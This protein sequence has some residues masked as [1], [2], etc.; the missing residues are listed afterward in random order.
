MLASMA[1]FWFYTTRICFLLKTTV[2]KRVFTMMVVAAAAA[3]VMTACNRNRVAD[4]SK[5]NPADTVGLAD[6]QQW[7]DANAKEPVV[8]HTNTKTVVVTQPASSQTAPVVQKKGW[9]KSAKYAVIGGVT[10]GVLGA[11][12]NKKNRAAGA[13]IG[14][15]IGGGGGYVIG[16]D[17]DKKDG[18]IH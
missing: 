1:S 8:T 12:V 6:Y 18:R 11:V 3:V 14:T 9:S 7:K 4:E 2:M 10:G 15:V 13:V 17:Q 5:I 16:R